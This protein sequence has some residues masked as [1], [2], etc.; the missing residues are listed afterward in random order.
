MDVDSFEMQHIKFKSS[1]L[2]TTK[3]VELR[4]TLEGNC[5]EKSAA[6]LNCW[7][8][9]PEAFTCLKK[10]AFALLS[11]FGS[12]C[13]CEQIFSHMKAVLSPQRSCLT[14]VHAEACVKREVTKYTPDIEQLTKEKQGQGSH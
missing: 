9:P 13:T 11:A 5:L 4:K 6:I 10:V 12:T 2:W 7:T 3:F 14:A 8:S 1:E